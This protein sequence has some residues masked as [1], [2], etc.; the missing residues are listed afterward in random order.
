MVFIFHSAY[1]RMSHYLKGHHFNTL[2]LTSW[3]LACV[4]TSIPVFL[5]HRCRSIRIGGCATQTALI[6][7]I[8]CYVPS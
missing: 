2:V 6:L 8:P 3:Y 5:T 1:D 4:D 7:K